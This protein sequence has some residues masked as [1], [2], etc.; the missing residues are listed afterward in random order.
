MWGSCLLSQSLLCC[1]VDPMGSEWGVEA[2]LVG[3]VPF[4]NLC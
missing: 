3:R 4:P 2:V 1:L